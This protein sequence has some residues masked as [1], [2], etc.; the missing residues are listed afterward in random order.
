MI[1]RRFTWLAIAALLAGCASARGGARGTSPK[2]SGG[3]D[4]EVQYDRTRTQQ[5]LSELLTGEGIAGAQ[6]ICPDSVTVRVGYSFEC[7][8]T[9]RDGDHATITVTDKDS[10]GDVDVTSEDIGTVNKKQI[11]DAIE[12]DLGQKA[13]VDC[14]DRPL[15]EHAG[16]T[17]TCDATIAGAKKRVV[18]TLVGKR[19]DKWSCT[20]K[21]AGNPQT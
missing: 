12:S 3:G 9:D 2:G 16:A 10:D 21:V 18:I 11:G 8:V 15:I 5:K 19:G 6:V 1:A 7:D 20:W 13:D 14:P 4:D 17:I